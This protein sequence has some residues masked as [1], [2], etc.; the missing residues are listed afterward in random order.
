[1]RNCKHYVKVIDEGKDSKS[2]HYF[3][4]G[5]EAKDFYHWALTSMH[6]CHITYH[7]CVSVGW[8]EPSEGLDRSV[9]ENTALAMADFYDRTE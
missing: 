7:E 2:Y 3:S 5:K 1:M 8:F 6:H 4:A 9:E